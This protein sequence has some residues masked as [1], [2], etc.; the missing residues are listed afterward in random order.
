MNCVDRSV[1]AAVAIAFALL[2]TGCGGGSSTETRLIGGGIGGG[3]GATVVSLDTPTGPNTTEI[4][5]D[6]GPASGFSL[7]AANI[8]YVTVTVC[9]PG[10]A[11]D[12]VTIDHVF[13]DTGSIGLR[14]LKSAVAKLSLPPIP[15]PANAA[16]STPAGHAVEC[17]PFVLGAVWGALASADVRIA[18]ELASSLP[19]QLIDDSKPP[20]DCRAGRLRRGRQRRAA[21]FLG[22]VAGQ[23]RPRRR[24]AV[25]RLRAQLRQG[26]YAS[27]YALYYSCPGVGGGACTPTGLARDAADAE[28]GGTFRGEQQRNGHRDAGTAGTRRRRSPRDDWC[29][30]SARSRTTRFRRRPRCIRSTRIRRAQVIST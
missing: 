6:S 28:S 15:A 9:T 26:N 30:A 17:Y 14:V 1:A 13:L 19:V 5:V 12:C 24:H 16:G 18:E 11:T 8:P 23:W 29:S 22:L 4:V 25:L 2:A 27:G 7:G 3:S 20:S 21:E 10:S